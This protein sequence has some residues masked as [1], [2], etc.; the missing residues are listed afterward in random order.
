MTHLLTNGKR[1]LISAASP[2]SGVASGSCLVRLDD[3]PVREDELYLYVAANCPGDMKDVVTR[4]EEFRRQAAATAQASLAA[5]LQRR[6]EELGAARAA[7]Y[8]ERGL[9]E[10]FEMKV[11]QENRIHRPDP[12]ERFDTLRDEYMRRVYIYTDSDEQPDG[13]QACR[14][15]LSYLRQAS[16]LAAQTWVHKRYKLAQLENELQHIP[17][18]GRAFWSTPDALVEAIDDCMFDEVSSVR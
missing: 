14:L 10:A 2:G 6:D 7:V 16:T 11:H 12:G 8:R 4:M 1:V 15:T 3:A 9:R 13:D 17:R 18:D 5:A